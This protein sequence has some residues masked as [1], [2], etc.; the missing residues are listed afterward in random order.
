MKIL[1]TLSSSFD[2]Q[3][4]EEEFRAFI[5]KKADHYLS[6]FRSF[7][8]G[9]NYGFAVTWNW[10]A[11][12]LGFI[13][14]LY[15]KMY[16]WAL[17]AFFITFTPVALPLTMIGW[18][19]VGNYLYYLHGRKKILEYKSRQGTTPIALSLSDLGGVNRWVWYIGFI[20]FLFL[21][22]IVVLGFFIFIYFLQGSFLGNPQSIEI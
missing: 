21:V 15:R 11:F 18:G 22:C 4:T 2:D 17:L 14:M 8:S 20:F 19:I 10:P 9:A 12:F 5:G 7:F 16:L 13:W 3:I 1:P 6:K